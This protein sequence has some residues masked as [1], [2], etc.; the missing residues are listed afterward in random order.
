MSYIKTKYSRGIVALL[1]TLPTLSNP[2]QGETAFCSEN[3]RLMTYDGQLWMCD[4]FIKLTNN[5]GATRN[6]GDL[7]V[8][9]TTSGTTPN[10]ANVTTI[11]ASDFVAGPVIY[12]SLENEP[13]AIAYKG[14]YKINCYYGGSAPT[15]IGFI[16]R[17]GAISAQANI[18]A[19]YV[20][21]GLFAYTIEIPTSEPS[22]VKCL[23]RNKVEY[24]L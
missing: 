24:S 9:E 1:S 16:V 13:V 7:M 14:I 17:C 10:L 18:A 23:L 8:F 11:F 19:T 20:S 3:G 6:A 15:T 2:E 5:S 21:P 12:Q 22:L 4:D